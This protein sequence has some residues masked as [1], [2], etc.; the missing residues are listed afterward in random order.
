MDLKKCLRSFCYAWRGIIW[1]I[2]TQQNMRIHLIAAVT[3]LAMAAWFQLGG[4][5]LA[6]VVIAVFLVLAGESINSAI[7]AA[8]DRIGPEQHPLAGAAKDAAAGAVLLLALHALIAALII[9]GPRLAGLLRFAFIAAMP[10][11]HCLSLV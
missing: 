8:V 6:W 10:E 9:F 1:V 2:K 3:A 7:E 5:E 4:W 11:A